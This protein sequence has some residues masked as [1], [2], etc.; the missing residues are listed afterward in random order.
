MS[1]EIGDK[2]VVP[3]L[4]VGIV[5][6]IEELDIVMHRPA[7]LRSILKTDLPTR[8]LHEYRV[9][10]HPRGDLCRRHRGCTTSFVTAKHLPTNNNRRYREYMN[11]IK[12]GDPLEV[13]AVPRPRQ[14][15]ERKDALWRTKDVRPSTFAHIQEIA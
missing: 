11:K 13:A 9:E 12:T 15:Q 7:V 3:A 4:G 5:K 2:A 8:F 1:F 10:R 14:T 6:E